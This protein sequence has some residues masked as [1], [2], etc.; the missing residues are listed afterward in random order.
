MRSTRALA[1]G[2]AL[3]ALMASAG[4]DGK[5]DSAGPDGDGKSPTATASSPPSGDKASPGRPGSSGSGGNSGSSS[6]SG[7]TTEQG[8]SGALPEASDMDT[9]ARQ[10]DLFTSCK[11]VKPGT[12]YDASHDGTDA[13]WGT[14][15]AADPSWGIKERA[16]CK[17]FRHPIA[18]LLISDMR[19]FQT[20]AKK[21][22][23]PFAIGKN[24][25]VVPVGD[26]QIEALSPSGLAFLTCA[27]DFSPPSG[28]RTEKALVDGCV[29]SDYFPT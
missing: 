14:Q 21:A 26:D 5:T 8:F 25:A 19:K 24:Y 10:I 12:E 11:E 1:V 13:A 6:S 7:S 29:L 23:A 9:L 3:A 20:A 22:N 15:E 2:A 17:D 4:C 18:L 28:H 16:V 27:P